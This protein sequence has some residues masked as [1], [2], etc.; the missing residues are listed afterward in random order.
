MQSLIATNGT[1]ISYDWPTERPH[2]AVVVRVVDGDT[3][4][5]DIDM[6]LKAWLK[7]FPVRLA[8]CNA[9]EKSTPAGAAA[10]AN[11]V[12]LLVPGTQVILT[13]IKDYKYGGEFIAKVW[14]LD[15]TDLVAS[16]I[17]QQWLAPWDGNGKQPV[18][19]WPRTV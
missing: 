14:L 5:C 6:D 11:L 17:A 4:H 12:G 7:D 1:P 9:A 10:A 18:P 2:F 8:G 15:G 16:L 19:P 13:T 3:V